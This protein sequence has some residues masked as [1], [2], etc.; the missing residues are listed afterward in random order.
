MKVL[1]KF[2]V[3]LMTAMSVHVL[4]SVAKAADLR[5]VDTCDYFT[6]SNLM[7]SAGG[8]S[9]GGTRKEQIQHAKQTADFSSMQKAEE[10]L[11]NLVSGK[12]Y[13]SPDGFTISGSKKDG[14]SFEV[15]K[16]AGSEVRNFEMKYKTNKDGTITILNKA[17]FGNGFKWRD[18]RA[19]GGGGKSD[20][21]AF[22]T[23]RFCGSKNW[24]L[25]KLNREK[26][27]CESKAFH[28]WKDQPDCECEESF[29][30]EGDIKMPWTKA[31]RLKDECEGKGPKDSRKGTTT[32]KWIGCHCEKTTTPKA[33]CNDGSAEGKIIYDEQYKK[34]ESRYGA[35]KF[36]FTSDCECNRKKIIIE[37]LCDGKYTS[38]QVE[39]MKNRCSGPGKTW[40][41]PGATG[42]DDNG[43]AVS[44]CSCVD[45]CY[46]VEVKVTPSP[47]PCF[48][49]V[50]KIGTVNAVDLKQL[51]CGKENNDLSV[52]ENITKQCDDALKKME[53]NLGQAGS[54]VNTT[55]PIKVDEQVMCEAGKQ[56]TLST[57][58]NANE[59]F[60]YNVPTHDLNKFAKA[61][62]GY[63]KSL[64][65]CS[66]VSTINKCVLSGKTSFLVDGKPIDIGQFRIYGDND[67]QKPISCS[68]WKKIVDSNN[69]VK[70]KAKELVDKIFAESPT[71]Q[72][73]VLT[74]ED[75][76]KLQDNLKFNINVLGTANR[77]N[78]GTKFT[79]AE[80]ASARREE[81][82]ALSQ[83]EIQRLINERIKTKYG[84]DYNF[85]PNV[86][87]VPEYTG[88]FGP[89]APYNPL[90]SMKEVVYEGDA[91]A[92]LNQGSDP[93]QLNL[94]TQYDLYDK[95]I[96]SDA[97]K[98]AKLYEDSVNHFFD[99]E[100]KKLTQPDLVGICGSLKKEDF[101]EY[102]VKDANGNV[103]ETLPLFNE[104]K[105][106]K[107]NVISKTIN[108]KVADKFR[109]EDS[110]FYALKRFDMSMQVTGE[111]LYQAPKFEKK[112]DIIVTCTA[113]VNSEMEWDPNNKVQ[114][115][116]VTVSKP[117][118][119]RRF[120]V[121]CREEKRRLQEKYGKDGFKQATKPGG[122]ITAPPAST[123]GK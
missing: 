17:L 113:K 37:K 84:L 60:P 89:L 59:D 97:V 55:F 21:E 41:G 95:T 78:N 38:D 91:P 58:G 117:G 9:V 86:S 76:K 121:D 115:G 25:D 14:K 24:T 34:C 2:L 98:K 28:T 1:L 79:L 72:K 112:G 80:L 45:S 42:T 100:C 101:L 15:K 107:G 93:N 68:E 7:D 77:S 56:A 35:G 32:Y 43:D 30:V 49:P 108:D 12:T 47:S 29:C 94:K 65:D 44:E 99:V 39:R 109:G 102:K 82:K 51:I 33:E 70:N 13:S 81:A 57:D 6:L 74:A 66:K 36:D 46:D 23:R 50:P 48:T 64:S 123:E 27:Q 118:F 96:K 111:E 52:N 10:C 5:P 119:F 120:K 110:P 92:W 69:G 87:L 18:P 40:Y 122:F 90:E 88:G 16:T 4:P 22:Y 85:Q 106:A 75:L 11:Q 54:S 61:C 19:N 71:L 83:S 53:L 20:G 8:E 116:V 103:V 31:N 105:D 67:Y 73:D 3:C 62:E 114:V 26:A 104:T 63:N